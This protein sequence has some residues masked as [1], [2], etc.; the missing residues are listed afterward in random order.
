VVIRHPDNTEVSGEVIDIVVPER[1]VFTY[2]NKSGHPIPP[3]GSLVTIRLTDE[4]KHTRLHLVHAFADREMRD[5]SIQGWRFQLSLFA[6]VVANEVHAGA[7]AVVDA[8]FTAWSEPD[9]A[10]RRTTLARV[11]APQIRFKDRFSLIDGVTELMVHLDAASR[12]MSGIR[13]E[14]EGEV[15]HCQGVVLADWVARAIDGGERSRGTNVFV[16]DSDGYIESVTGF[17]NQHPQK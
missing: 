10:V 12:F 3:G 7:A 8:W 16:L 15:R 4:G 5:Q 13:L 6:N 9:S 11:A 2:G 14:R 17:W 1:I